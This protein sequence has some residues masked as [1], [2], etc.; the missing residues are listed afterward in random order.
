[1]Y[2][3][4]KLRLAFDILE[5]K[6]NDKNVIAQFISSKHENYMKRGYNCC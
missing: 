6:Q 4:K 2:S 1:M 3:L 5:K